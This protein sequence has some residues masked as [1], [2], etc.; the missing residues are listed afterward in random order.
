MNYY[1]IYP[2]NNPDDLILDLHHVNVKNM[3]LNYYLDA[4]TFQC[5]MLLLIPNL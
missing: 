5:K 1:K 4:P 3:Q 2:L